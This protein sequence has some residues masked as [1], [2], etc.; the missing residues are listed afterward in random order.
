M[1]TTTM[2]VYY[3]VKRALQ[4]CSEA[5]LEYIDC[6]M[7]LFFLLVLLLLL[8]LLSFTTGLHVGNSFWRCCCCFALLLLIQ[9][10]GLILI[11]Q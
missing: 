5:L 11:C 7:S 2:K 10:L 6:L 1:L 4:V 9:K 3:T 8:L